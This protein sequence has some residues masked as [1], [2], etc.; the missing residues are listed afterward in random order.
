MDLFSKKDFF[1]SWNTLQFQ[2]YELNQDSRKSGTAEGG[3]LYIQPRDDLD[4]QT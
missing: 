2:V 1:L 3:C 4:D